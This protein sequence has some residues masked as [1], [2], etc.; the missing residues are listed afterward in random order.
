MVNPERFELSFDLVKSQVQSNFAIG[1]S[2]PAAFA[3]NS[4]ELRVDS[5]GESHWIDHQ[6]GWYP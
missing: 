5:A 6:S 4:R 2:V 1:S 3:P